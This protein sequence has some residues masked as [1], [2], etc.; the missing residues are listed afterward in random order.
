[1]KSEFAKET[2]FSKYMQVFS[3]ENTH[4]PK[5][6]NYIPLCFYAITAIKY[7][8]LMHLSLMGPSEIVETFEF[9][10]QVF[11]TSFGAQHMLMLAYTQ[12]GWGWCNRNPLVGQII[13]DPYNNQRTT[14]PVL[15][16]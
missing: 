10:A 14:G 9:Q 2:A 12:R 13:F 6:F 7:D 15:L 8:F 11:N 5:H 16:T 4:L 3:K 1:M